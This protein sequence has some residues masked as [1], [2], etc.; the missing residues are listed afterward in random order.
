MGLAPQP[1]KV[2][3]NAL[4]QCLAAPGSGDAA[5]AASPP[6]ALREGGD[7]DGA[8]VCSVAGQQYVYTP[9]GASLWHDS[10]QA[11]FSSLEA[12]RGLQV[13][14]TTQE[15]SKAQL[16]GQQVPDGWQ[17]STLEIGEQAQQGA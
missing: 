4:Q 10:M 15:P 14:W 11:L 13:Q 17:L 7:A 12:A 9:F 3:P 8:V 6:A 5:P 1:A 16:L 2:Q